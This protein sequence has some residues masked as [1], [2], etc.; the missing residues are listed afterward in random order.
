MG[1]QTNA[2]LQE[3]HVHLLQQGTT[4]VYVLVM[5]SDTYS[6]NPEGPARRPELHIQSFT[7]ASPER[8][9]IENLDVWCLGDVSVCVPGWDHAQDPEI[10]PCLQAYHGIHP[11]PSEV[12]E[13]IEVLAL[14]LQVDPGHAF[15]SGAR[16][17]RDHLG[18]SIRLRVKDISDSFGRFCVWMWFNVV[19]KALYA[20]SFWCFFSLVAALLRVFDDMMM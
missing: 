13:V 12:M 10:G 8:L 6:T 14:F 7:T 4:Q 2:P 16:T 17:S 5:S 20:F 9:K 1:I 11:H 18:C 15:W 3:N 19:S